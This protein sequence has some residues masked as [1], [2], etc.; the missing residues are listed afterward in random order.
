MYSFYQLE[1]LVAEFHAA[2]Y[3]INEA[4]ATN[5]R[6]LWLK[7]DSQVVVEGFRAF[8]NYI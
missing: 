3:A 7:I 5:W 2:L 6:N 1:K 8:N 4:Q